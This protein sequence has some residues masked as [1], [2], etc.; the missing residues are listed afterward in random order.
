MATMSTTALTGADQ[1]IETLARSENFPVGSMLLPARLRPHVGRYYRFARTADDVGDSP[2]LSSDEKIRLLNVMDAAVAGDTASVADED[3]WLQSIGQNLHESLR[4]LDIPLSVG[5]D[6]LIAFR[7]DAENR[8]YAEWEDVLTYCAYSANPVGR[9]LLGLNG[10]PVSNTASDALCTALQILNHI[11]DVKDDYVTLNR[12]YVP[13]NWLKAKGLSNQALAR[14]CAS[15]CLMDVFA[16]MLDRTNALLKEADDLPGSISSRG[17]RMEA[18]VI[19]SLAHKLHNRLYRADPVIRELGLNKLDWM[20]GAV[21][22]V[23]SG[24]FKRAA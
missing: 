10:E 18:S 3:R 7:W 22:G 9:F 11:Q 2:T 12:V 17:L 20:T 23:A 8:R 24:F 16:E 15:P 21:T 19:V 1:D 13:Q 4:E 6:L 14:H 5:R